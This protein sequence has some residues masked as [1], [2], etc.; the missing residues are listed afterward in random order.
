MCGIFGQISSFDKS[1]DI[2]EILSLLKHRGPDANGCFAIKTD[3]CS[4][5]LGHTRL[6]IIDLSDKASQPMSDETLRYTI[7]F[8]GEIYNYIEIKDEL[9]E[10]GVVFTAQ[11]DTEVLL[12]SWVQWGLNFP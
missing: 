10:L 2:N 9:L 7:V 3:N 5:K 6:S 11:S 4:G 1:I 12:K 8:N